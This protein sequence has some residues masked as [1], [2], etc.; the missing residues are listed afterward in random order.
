MIFFS[1]SLLYFLLTTLKLL[2]FYISTVSSGD[3]CFHIYSGFIWP[4]IL[5]YRL[6]MQ[7]EG[8]SF[9]YRTFPFHKCFYVVCIKIWKPSY[10]VMKLCL[11][12]YLLSFR[13]FE[14]QFLI[15]INWKNWC[16]TIDISW[17]ASTKMLLSRELL[18]WMHMETCMQTWLWASFHMKL[19]FIGWFVIQKD[20]HES[21]EWTDTDWLIW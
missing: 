21:S 17:L 8:M 1:W 7:T 10:L 19:A 20:M 18:I 12:L 16:W 2:R 11:L 4:V 13:Q 3:I 9:M 6:R 5:G 15:D 14:W